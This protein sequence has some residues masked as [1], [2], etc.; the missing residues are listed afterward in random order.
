MVD[1]N[2]YEHINKTPRANSTAIMILATKTEYCQP[3]KVVPT[4][5]YSNGS[6]G[7]NL[8]YAESINNIPKQRLKKIT[9]I[10][11]IMD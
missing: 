11:F 1:F 8:K 7:H 9:A 6:I 2:R 3:I 10:F 4:I 5:L